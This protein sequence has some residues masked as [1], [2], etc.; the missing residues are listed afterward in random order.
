M[1]NSASILLLLLLTATVAITV[2]PCF[3][4]QMPTVE[5]MWSNPMAVWDLKVS[6]DGNYIAAVNETG[7]YYFA[8]ND[9]NPR[10]WKNIPGGFT[11]VA[12]SADGKYVIAG[13]MVG[14]N[15]FYFADA[16]EKIG[17]ITEATWWSVSL[18][19]TVEPGTLDI[20]DDGEYVVV[21]GTG[22][23]VYY[24]ADCTTRSG[25]GQTSTW[26]DM[27]DVS[28]IR[29]V[30]MSPN[31]RY[32]VAGGYNNTIE[33]GF[34]VFYKDANTAPYPTKPLWDAW[35][36]VNE[37]ILDIAVSDDG[38]AVTAVTASP[39]KTLYYWAEA[40]TL[41]GDP[42]ATWKSEGY[43][44][45]VDTSSDG[46][47]VVAG[48]MPP[49]P[50]CLHF[51]AEARSRTG[52][53]EEETWIELKDMDVLDVAISDDG[54]IVA[55]TTHIGVES[56]YNVYFFTSDGEL[57]DGFELE[58]FSPLISM[59]GDGSIV[60]VGGPGFDSIYTFKITRHVP[61]GGE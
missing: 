58:S 41:T 33:P 49:I 4:E 15:I 44:R 6:K 39:P 37:T 52:P 51:W 34:V 13:S 47:E 35:S 46:D 26:S 8:V 11:S 12:V 23:T 60:A 55:A 28:D 19:G 10:W 5:M 9:P 3:P 16:D 17:E 59:S 25:S 50:P 30:D 24:F 31:G 1:K 2:L 42:S 18:G 53:L 14:E 57:I 22:P 45:S 48:G 40:T 56:D 7:L 21:G 29:A 61:V 54:S 43:F 36:K 27:L 32:V 38:Y 20:S